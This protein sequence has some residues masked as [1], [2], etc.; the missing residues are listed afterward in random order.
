METQRYYRKVTYRIPRGE[1][2][3]FF[4]LGAGSF[5]KDLKNVKDWLKESESKLIYFTKTKYG[6]S[7]NGK[8]LNIIK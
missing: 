4:W 7:K 2:K 5:A 3:Y 8:G 1:T 6:S